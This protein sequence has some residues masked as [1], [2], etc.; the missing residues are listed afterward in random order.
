[1]HSEPIQKEIFFVALWM[2]GGGHQQEHCCAGQEE[3]GQKEAEG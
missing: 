1:M 2:D 3:W